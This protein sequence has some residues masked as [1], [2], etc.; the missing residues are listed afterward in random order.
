MK[1]VGVK[2]IIG[3]I[4]GLNSIEVSNQPIY[5]MVIDIGSFERDELLIDTVIKI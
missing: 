3:R 2:F 5:E 4:Q 1:K